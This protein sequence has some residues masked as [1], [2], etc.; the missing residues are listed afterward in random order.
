MP[1]QMP[2]HPQ[3]LK[4]ESP[5]ATGPV[6]SS[7]PPKTPE[8]SSPPP[9][10]P[11]QTPP[12]PLQTTTGGRFSG[13]SRIV[14]ASLIVVGLAGLGLFWTFGAP[15]KL[16]STADNAASMKV[17]VTSEQSAPPTAT[18]ALAAPA[19]VPPAPTPASAA[20]VAAAPAAASAASDGL[21][22]AR[23]PANPT[24][25]P[26]APAKSGSPAPKAGKIHFTIKP[27][28]EIVVDG[29]RRGVSPPIK[30]LSVPEG[31][32]RIEIRNGTS[33]RYADEVDIKAGRKVSI[34]HSFKSP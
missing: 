10:T 25:V 6:E 29:K 8:Q 18:L 3:V 27:W 7:P 19:T 26:T 32:H 16:S 14:G 13:V 21:A 11:E 22:P 28:G 15:E 20:P 31:R 33:S 34:V 5:P 12:L 30:E 17:A 23:R 24:T 9:K 4:Q 2:A 1:E